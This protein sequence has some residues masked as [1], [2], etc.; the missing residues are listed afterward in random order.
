MARAAETAHII[1]RAC[2][3]TPEV[4]VDVHEVG[5]LFQ[6]VRPAIAASG[7]D[8]AAPAAAAGSGGA[9]DA[10]KYEGVPGMSRSALMAAY[11]GMQAGAHAA[12]L[13]E[14]GWWHHRGRETEAQALERV[15]GVLAALRARAAALGFAHG[16]YAEPEAAPSPSLA[17]ATAAAGGA[18]SVDPSQPAPGAFD[19]PLPLAETAGAAPG[20]ASTNATAPPGLGGMGRHDEPARA[21]NPYGNK[22]RARDPTSVTSALAVTA[23]IAGT[24]AAAAAATGETI[25]IVCHGDF[26]DTLFRLIVSGEHGAGGA[27]AA[28]GAP[29]LQVCHNNC[30]VSVLD[31]F[32]DGGVRIVRL[33]D[34]RHLTTPAA[35]LAAVAMLGHGA[36][37]AEAG[38]DSRLAAAAAAGGSAA[39]AT[40]LVTGAP[41]G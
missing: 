38:L 3:A 30:G 10:P 31:V 2:G 17:E 37:E 39:V 11:P 18:S 28:A 22:R 15:R 34:V 14:A 26:L 23:P 25:A 21:P 20:A 32:P 7:A 29:P 41:L 40:G 13:T 8:T 4:W 27:G 16:I 6:Q 1:A 9:S 5:G 36:G 12:A 19:T 33:N 24:A 35:A